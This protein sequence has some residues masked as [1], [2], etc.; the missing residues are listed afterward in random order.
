MAMT[1]AEE[2][3]IQS[4]SSSSLV[5]SSTTTS[6]DSTAADDEGAT[7]AMKRQWRGVEDAVEDDVAT[8]AARYPNR[9]A[10]GTK[11]LARRTTILVVDKR[12]RN[13]DMA[14]AHSN[15]ILGYPRT[16]LY[17]SSCWFWILCSTVCLTLCLTLS[18]STPGPVMMLFCDVKSTICGP[19]PCIG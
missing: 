5:G 12:T 9:A 13:D 10:A 7:V 2:C 15:F 19:S 16:W 8:T 3:R 1:C 14:N 18:K 17:S 11:A 4:S 6:D